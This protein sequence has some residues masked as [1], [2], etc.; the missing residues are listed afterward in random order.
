MSPDDC[1]FNTLNQCRA[2]VSGTSRSCTRNLNYQGK[3]K[4]R[5]AP[6]N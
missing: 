5:R 2:A 4:R 6:R 3:Q 1:S